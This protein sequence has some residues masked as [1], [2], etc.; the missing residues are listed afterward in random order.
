MKIEFGIH[1]V[2]RD[3]EGVTQLLGR[4]FAGVVQHGT[5]FVQACK[6]EH[7]SPEV[8]PLRIPVTGINLT[9]IGIYAYGRQFETLDEG[10][11]GCVMVTGHA[12]TLKSG[13]SVI[14]ESFD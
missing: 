1:K 3:N 13:M 8:A 12:E 14:A 7:T 5:R 9:V 6:I 10:L 2:E 11:T 4:V